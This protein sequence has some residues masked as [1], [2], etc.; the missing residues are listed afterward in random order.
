[1]CIRDRPSAAPVRAAEGGPGAI[2]GGLPPHR[3]RPNA[4]P[5]G[6]QRYFE[7]GIGIITRD[8][9]VLGWRAERVAWS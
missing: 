2:A 1:M 4:L 9:Y 5:R 8:Y 6:G 7:V 3:Q